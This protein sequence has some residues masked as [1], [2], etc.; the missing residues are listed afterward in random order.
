[1]YL[2][3][4]SQYSLRYGTMSIPNLVE[5]AAAR[6]ITQMVLTDINNSTGI[7]EFMRV[8]DEH[9]IKPIVGIEFRRNKHLLY[10]G[11]AQ[12]KEGMRELNEFLSEHNLEK[13]PLPDSAPPF[14]I[15]YTVYP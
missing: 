2:N 14:K 12:N 3:V 13:K 6:G 11:I 15:A 4:H 8:C 1:M 5:E 7:I 9:G 10:V